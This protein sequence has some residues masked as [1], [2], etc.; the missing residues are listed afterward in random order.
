MANSYLQFSTDIVDLT[1]VESQWLKNFEAAHIH[2]AEDGALCIEKNKKSFTEKHG[3]EMLKLMEELAMNGDGIYLDFEYRMN[4]KERSLW[5]YS[6]EGGNS[7][8]A[9]KFIQLFFKKFRK[10]DTHVLSWA[11]WCDKLRADEFGGGQIVITADWLYFEPYHTRIDMLID[12][13]RAA[14]KEKP[15]EETSWERL[16]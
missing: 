4:D 7:E 8:Q 9:A 2:W 5:I 13:Y 1:Y 16:L 14:K 11:T 12:R 10:A 3:E 15:E 6:E